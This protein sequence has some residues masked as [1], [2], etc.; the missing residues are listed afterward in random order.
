M[1]E[2]V[3]TALRTG[4]LDLEEGEDGTI[5]EVSQEVGPLEENDS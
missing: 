1:A 3:S 4:E 5:E 2:D